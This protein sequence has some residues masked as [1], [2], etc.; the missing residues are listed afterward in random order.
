MSDC[1]QYEPL[2][3]TVGANKTVAK[4]KTDTVSFL[5]F[6]STNLNT[7]KAATKSK[8]TDI[9]LTAYKLPMGR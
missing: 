6:L 7:K 8:A 1:P 3:I 2:R 4:E 9:I 5:Y